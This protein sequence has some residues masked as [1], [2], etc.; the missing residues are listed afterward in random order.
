MRSRAIK[1]TRAGEFVPTGA[2]E[3]EFR[4]VDEVRPGHVGTVADER[5]DP[6]DVTADA[7]SSIS[8]YAGIC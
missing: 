3:T 5:V 2:G 7:R 6:V 1:I 4:V 8:P